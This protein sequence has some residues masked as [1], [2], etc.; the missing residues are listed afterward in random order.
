MGALENQIDRYLRQR[1][2]DTD[3]ETLLEEFDLTATEVLTILYRG[4]HLD[5][6]Y[7]LQEQEG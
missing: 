3:L 4:G 5:L 1:L 7:V 6:D 2:E